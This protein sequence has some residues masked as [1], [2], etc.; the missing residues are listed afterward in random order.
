M[1][2]TAI[3]NNLKSTDNMKG[4]FNGND[5]NHNFTTYICVL[6]EDGKNKENII[7]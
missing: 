4:Y 3:N 1:S 5:K 2:V 7:E 6:T